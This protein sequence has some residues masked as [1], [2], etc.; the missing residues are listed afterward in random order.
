MQKPELVLGNL[1]PPIQ[2][3]AFGGM[4]SPPFI[5]DD[6]VQ[7]KER[8]F[9][10]FPVAPPVFQIEAEAFLRQREPDFFFEI[11]PVFFRHSS[12]KLFLDLANIPVVVSP[13]F[14]AP[15]GPGTIP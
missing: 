14:L 13:A 7:G 8:G 3:L 1:S 6:E 5:Q 9:L 12:A 11:L 15:V 4:D 2:H 10:D